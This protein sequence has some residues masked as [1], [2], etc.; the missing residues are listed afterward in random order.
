MST[1]VMVG[2]TIS[3]NLLAPKTF[4]TDGSEHL[5]VPL[6]THLSTACATTYEKPWLCRKSCKKICEDVIN[7]MGQ[8]IVGWL[9]LE[10]VLNL[11]LIKIYNKIPASRIVLKFM[12]EN[13]S[14]YRPEMEKLGFFAG[15]MSG[16]LCFWLK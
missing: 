6:P 8:N 1:V 9:K 15:P 10:T 12:D 3:W 11:T 16:H 4:L 13:G 5:R 7:K 14:Q 2:T